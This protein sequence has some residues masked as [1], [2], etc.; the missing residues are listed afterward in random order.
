VNVELV[1]PAPWNARVDHDVSGIIESIKRF[2]F[3]DPIEVIVQ[4]GDEVQD[5][6]QL[7]VAGAGRYLAMREMGHVEIPAELQT[8]DS[9]TSARAYGL[10]NNKL[11]DASRFD[12][13]TVL[14]TLEEL[15]PLEH[16][17]TGTGFSLGDLD[18]MRRQEHGPEDGS[19]RVQGDENELPE[20]ADEIITKRGDVW[21]VGPHR[22]MCGDSTSRRD[23]KRLLDVDADLCFTSPPYGDQRTYEGEGDLDPR[24]LAKFLGV[25]ADRCDLFAVNLG[26]VRRDHAVLRYWDEYIRAGEDAGLKLL[27]WN[28]WDRTIAGTISQASAMFPIEHEFVLVLGQPRELRKTVANKLAGDVKGAG[29]N[30]RA[31]DGSMRDFKEITVASH[32]AMGTV[33]RGLYQGG[34]G[35]EHPAMFPVAF[36][37]AYIAACTDKGGVIYEPF[38]GSGT[39]MVAAHKLERS[40]HGMELNPRYVDLALRRMVETC[41]IVPVREGDGYEIH[42]SDIHREESDA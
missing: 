15:A 38:L 39:T 25:V 23:V 9:M 31:A 3:R 28:V 22:V 20:E 19:D 35:H 27:S 12:R 7:I 1:T 18:E 33:Y 4:I 41:G 17:L 14:A 11:T 5:A 8:W 26:I 2:G 34:V 10:A 24:H 21:T 36:P 32:R 37:E 40:C 6:P 29:P 30:M 16:G 13:G 42:P